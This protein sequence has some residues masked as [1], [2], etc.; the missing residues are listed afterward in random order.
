MALHQEL[1]KK[2]MENNQKEVVLYTPHIKQ[3]ELHNLC[4]VSSNN[5]WTVCIA[6][7]QSGKSLA[8]ENQAIYWALS[9]PRCLIWYVMPTEGQVL[10]KYNDILKMVPNES[11]LIKSH[12]ATKGAIEI[13]WNN[14]SRIQFKSASSGDNLRGATVNYMIID[15]AAWIK[16]ETMMTSIMP[17]LNVGG[18]KG[19]IISTPKGK[20]WLFN[21]YLKGLDK[22]NKDYRSLKFTSNDNP[23]AN[24]AIIEMAKS[25]TPEEYFNQ[26]YMAEFV[27]SASVFRNIDEISILTLQSEPLNGEVYHAG[28]DIG[29]LHDDT[30]ISVL[31]NKGEMVYYDAF[32]KLETPELKERLLVTLRKW[33][34][35]S[36]L[37]EENNQGLVILQLLG[38]EWPN[39]TGFVTTNESKGEIINQ[40]IAAFSS[41]E[42]KLIKDDKLQLQL[43][44]FIFE[45]TSTGKV[46][47]KA[48][49]GFHDDMVMSLAIAWESF[50]KNKSGN[51]YAVMS[52]NKPIS[53]SFGSKSKD[54]M[55]NKY[56]MLTQNKP[57]GPYDYDQEL[58]IF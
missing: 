42:I 20:N 1:L 54:S 30:V 24:K 50:V 52:E 18:K 32:T 3:E 15:E 36:C 46:R 31:N 26:E 17:T 19:L 34:P 57:K 29:M 27:D 14:G 16:E 56:T 40:L 45:M 22:N 49:N 55:P 38:R 28:I 8:A 11:N 44:G 9:D 7:R 10:E 37:I 12:K 2:T 4:D 5:F 23:F 25:N 41:K 21:W 53:V 47:Y 35:I 48:A 39:I 6:G 43:Q 58:D 33:N 13:I 51:R